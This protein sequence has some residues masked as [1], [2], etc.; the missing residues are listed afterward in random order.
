MRGQAH[1]YGKVSVGTASCYRTEMSGLALAGGLCRFRQR[2]IHGHRGMI[3]DAI[4]NRFIQLAHRDWKMWSET[5]ALLP[6]TWIL[7]EGFNEDPV[8]LEPA[9]EASEVASERVGRGEALP[10][11]LVAI[12]KSPTL[13]RKCSVARASKIEG[14][15]VSEAELLHCLEEDVLAIVP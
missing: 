12:R 4:G 8:D 13:G 15:T 10:P 14:S 11:S 3:R 5:V 7:D 6:A 1:H 2:Q 9:Q